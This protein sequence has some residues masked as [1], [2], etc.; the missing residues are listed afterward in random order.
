[1]HPENNTLVRLAG[2]IAALL[3]ATALM[4]VGLMAGLALYPAVPLTNPQPTVAVVKPVAAPLTLLDMQGLWQAPS[5]SDMETQP[6]VGQLRY[7]REL[8]ANTSYYFGPNGVKGHTSNGMNCQNC[9]LNAG[10][11]PYG[12]SYGAVASTYPRFRERSGTEE[13]IQKRINDCFERSLNGQTLA[14]D[15]EEMKAMVAYMEWLGKDVPKG[16]PPKGA[17]IYELAFLDRA[18]N[19]QKGKRVYQL[20]CA[21]CHGENGQGMPAPD[22]RG[23]AYPPLWGEHSFSDAAGLFRLS[24]MAGYVYTSMPLGA[25]PERPILSE[26]QAWDVAAYINSLDRPHKSF[27]GDWPDISK[28]PIDHP[29]GPFADEF[30]E[31]Q[32]KFGPY[33]PILKALKKQWETDTTKIIKRHTEE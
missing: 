5:F 10:T 21:V 19:P 33:L 29:F 16:Q 9:H 6:N 18:A 25:T 17:G 22:G 23:F 27:P 31:E 28:K 1:M 20:Q 11:S 24:R 4:V 13:T 14:G 12:N 7:G 15:S 30:S 26:E 3:G 8:I 32:H 2:L